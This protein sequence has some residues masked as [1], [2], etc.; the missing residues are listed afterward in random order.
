MICLTYHSLSV[1]LKTFAAKRLSVL[2][3]NEAFI[4]IKS[5]YSLLIGVGEY[6]YLSVWTLRWCF[7]CT[8]DIIATVNHICIGKLDEK[9]KLLEFWFMY[10]DK[11]PWLDHLNL[12]LLH[13]ISSMFCLSEYVVIVLNMIYHNMGPSLLKQHRWQKSSPCWA[14]H[15]SIEYTIDNLKVIIFSC[16]WLLHSLLLMPYV[17]FLIGLTF[18]Q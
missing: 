1:T 2:A 7:I 9:I 13:F 17:E 12:L 5:I 11:I 3:R 6:P 18:I 4:L 8:T 10:F 16:S 14:G 15:H